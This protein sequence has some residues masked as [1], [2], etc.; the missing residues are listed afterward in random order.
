MV[1][2]DRAPARSGGPC[3]GY[4]Q[5]LA[6]T[7]QIGLFLLLGLLVFPS[8][9]DE[10]ALGRAR[11]GHRPRAASPGRSPCVLSIAWLGFNRRELTL[12]SWAGLRG[13]VPIVLATF[14]LTAGY[15]DG[16]LI[17]DVVFFVVIVSVLVQGFTLEPARDAAGPRRR[18]A[19]A[20]HGGRG[21]ARSTRPGAEALEIE[22]GS[23]ARHRRPAAPRRAT[24]ARGACRGRA[25]RRRGGGGHGRRPSS[26]PAIGWS[27]S[28]RP[29]AGPA[30]RPRSVGGRPG[31][32]RPPTRTD[33]AQLRP[34]A[35]RM[36]ANT[37][38]SSFHAS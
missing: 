16:Q 29:A 24:A 35:S 37:N 23:S 25:P 34:R 13:A 18:A 31:R 11:R 26:R 15:P 28:R 17:F 32:R 10:Q 7:A 19:V 21:A 14:P 1:V 5:A 12:V 22:V 2:A 8:R 20:R 27:C 33:A 30:R 38:A 36:K 3:S 9:L 6:S 4:L